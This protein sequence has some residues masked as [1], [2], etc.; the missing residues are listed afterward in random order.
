MFTNTHNI[1]KNK[2]NTKGLTV[3]R[4]FT[5]MWELSE[6][7]CNYQQANIDKAIVTAQPVKVSW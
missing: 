4:N 3:H 5:M 2:V 6:S 7:V 1:N